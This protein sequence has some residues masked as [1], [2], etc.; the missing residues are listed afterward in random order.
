M[1]YVALKPARQSSA[2]SVTYVS[3][4]YTTGLLRTCNALRIASFPALRNDELLTH[5]HFLAT[6]V[7]TSVIIHYS[8][9]IVN[10]QNLFPSWEGWRVAPGWFPAPCADATNV[11]T[12][13]PIPSVE[14]CRPQAAGWSYLRPTLQSPPL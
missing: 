1:R 7:Q 9:S 5:V 13:V 4:A 12:P 11:Q 6:H 10:C 3:V 8:L 2:G 14:G